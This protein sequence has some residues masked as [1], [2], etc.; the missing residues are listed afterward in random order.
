MDQGDEGRAGD[1]DGGDDLDTHGG[2]D[3]LVRQDDADLWVHPGER[4]A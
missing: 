4:D 1:A 3:L 2:R